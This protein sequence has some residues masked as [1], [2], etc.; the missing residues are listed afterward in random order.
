ML[1]TWQAGS[2][3]LKSRSRCPDL[4]RPELSAGAVSAECAGRVSSKGMSKTYDSHGARLS[5][6]EIGSGVPIIFLHPTPLDHTYWLPCIG[7][8]RR[9]PRYSAG[10]SRARRVGTGR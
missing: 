10:F 3:F 6:E 5:Y 4:T 9:I 2:A 1:R 7:G 8:A